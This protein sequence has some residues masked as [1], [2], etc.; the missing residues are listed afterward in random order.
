MCFNLRSLNRPATGSIIMEFAAALIIVIPMMLAIVL[1]TLEVTQAYL[2][3][4]SLTQL[5]EMAARELALQFA[6][7]CS[8]ASASRAK[9]NRLVFDKIRLQ[10][11]VNASEQ[12]DKPAFN[13]AGE[14]KSVSVTVR[15]L[16]GK[17]NLI[18]FPFVDPLNIGSNFQL[19]GSATYTLQ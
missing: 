17:H 11:V 13:I 4:T 15:Y 9:Q 1:V 2:L 5:A 6:T 12:F 3:K 14:C 8:V 16:S 7:D 18:P 19:A 10:G